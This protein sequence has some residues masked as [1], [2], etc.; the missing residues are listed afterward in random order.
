MIWQV[1]NHG[2]VRYAKRFALYP[3]RVKDNQDKSYVVWFG[4]YMAYQTYVNNEWRT[5]YRLSMDAY[6][7]RAKYKQLFTDKTGIKY[8]ADTVQDILN[9]LDYNSKV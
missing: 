6:N 9:N 7:E 4:M 8:N 2:D 5:D 3:T 1:P